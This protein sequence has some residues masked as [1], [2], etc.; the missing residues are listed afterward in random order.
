MRRKTPHFFIFYTT[1]IT[2]LRLTDQFILLRPPQDRDAPAIYQA[3]RESLAELHP[4]M[5][6]AT[7]AYDQDSTQRWL[8]FAQLAWLHS[9]ALHF[10]ITD[11]DSGQYLGSC[12]LDGIDEKNRRCNLGYW[13]RT[14]QSG[15]GIASS[16]ARLAAKFAFETKSL[17]RV[18]IIIAAGNIASRRAA[19]KSGAHFEGDLK[20]R[21][22]VRTDV[23]DAALYSF[24]PADFAF[25]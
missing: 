23:H 24:S 9:S 21:L 18:E 16:A 22:V 17:I 11:P 14:S 13:V 25:S 6:W 8:E 12:G 10:V 7:D 4:W 15:K 3:V 2:N 19:Q 1:L 20:N 5:D